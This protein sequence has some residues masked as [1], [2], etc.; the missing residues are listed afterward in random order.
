MAW[1]LP[2][3]APR[4]DLR[5]GAAL[6]SLADLWLQYPAL[7]RATMVQAALFGSFSAFWTVLALHLQEPKFHLGADA[8]GLFGVVGA[9]G[10]LAAPVAGRIADR[11][12][13]ALV[14]AAGALLSA[15]SWLLFGFWGALPGLVLGVIVLDFGVQSALISN[16]HVVFALRPEARSRINTVFMTGMFFGGSAGSAGA[17]FAWGVAGWTAVCGFG[18]MLALVAFIAELIGRRAGRGGGIA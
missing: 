14:I 10:I 5:Y 4:L 12:G 2:R 7:R 11:R 1:L 9:V 18:A 13:P 16:Q 8:A 17:T 3:N 15:L 6:A